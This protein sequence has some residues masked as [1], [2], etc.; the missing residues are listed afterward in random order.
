VKWTKLK[1]AIESRF[2]KSV[3]RRVTC[4]Q[5]RYRS[6]HE[7]LGRIWIAVDGHQI[8]EFSSAKGLRRRSELADQ[9]RE[10]SGNPQYGIPGQDE[11][12]HLADRQA[13][14]IGRRAGEQTD[15]EVLD[16]LA[17]SLS[18][19]L[20]G[21]LSSPSPLVRGLALLDR[22]LGKRRL[23]QLAFGVREHPLV[24]ALYRIRCEADGVLP[25]VPAA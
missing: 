2:A 19:S 20:E 9:I 10:V 18:L 16:E 23:R 8:A 25:R 7:E 15:D 6:S 22:R 14:A 13:R 5:A 11:L 17:E 3:R 21:A 4:H 1:A 24:Q 12:Y